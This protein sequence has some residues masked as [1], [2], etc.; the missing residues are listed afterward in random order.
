MSEPETNIHV[1]DA[2]YKPFPSFS[3]WASHTSVDR[4]RWDRYL[5]S[6][7]DKSNLSPEVLSRAYEIVKRAAA[8]DTGAIEGLY[9]VDRGFTFTVAFETAAWEVEL[10]KKGENVRPLFEAQLHAYDYV[11]D[12]ATKAEPISEAAIRVLHEEVCRAQA[13]YRVATSIG[14]QEQPLT[15][16]RYKV[17][18]NHV[19]TRD[20]VDHSYA[21]VDVTPVEMARLVRE[22]RTDQFLTAHPVLQAA[23][24]HYGLVAIHPFA[25]GN[26]RVARA[27]ASAFTYRAISMPIMILS[28]HK[29][30]YLDALEAADG[31]NYQQF[32]SFLLAR[33]LDTIQLVGESLLGALTPLAE[34]SVE[35]INAMYFTKGGYTKEQV[36]EA[37][38]KLLTIIQDEL[39][40]TIAK[41]VTAMV[42]GTAYFNVGTL[43]FKY[44]SQTNQSQ[45]DHREHSDSGRQ[46]EIDF[47]SASPF[48]AKAARL[49]H[50][51]IPRD[52]S[53]ED[54]FQLRHRDGE[55]IFAARI[56]EIIPSVSGV[57]RIRVTLFAERVV[58]E[59]LAEL[60][61][62]AERALP[63][64]G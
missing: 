42:R 53:G 58:G 1:L 4:V 46:L 2:A 33:S 45:K 43:S 15:K 13:T 19:R 25:D 50:L 7:K 16:G 60:K 14:F 24:A 40:K 18:P 17:L 55:I 48:E 49:Y 29:E 28:E 20:G 12:L 21:P 38:R 32:V 36:E 51:F 9:E 44:P 35:A 56:D 64:R 52:A 22:L 27:L 34:Q 41:N 47:S 11:L 10:A 37:G 63:G 8:L 57:L 54:D 3:E 31:G 59:M 61:S 6:I 26:G 62:R 23:Y 39:T 5:A 30:S